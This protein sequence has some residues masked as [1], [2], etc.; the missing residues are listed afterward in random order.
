MLSG[1][2]RACRSYLS[3]AFGTF[4]G[5]LM[6]CGAFGHLGARVGSEGREAGTICAGEM[7]CFW[8]GGQSI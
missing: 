5:D 8:R 2:E 3:F 1:V 7:E 4:P 6:V